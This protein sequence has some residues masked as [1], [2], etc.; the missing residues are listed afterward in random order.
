M[1]PGQQILFFFSALGAF[2]GLIIS[3]YLLI[4][5]KPKAPASYFLGLLLLALTMRITKAVF[6]YFYP[7]LPRIYLQI[8]LSGCFLI[9]PSLFYFTRAALENTVKTPVRWKY[10][11]CAWLV[12]ITIL[13]ILIPYQ[14]HPWDWNHYIVHII[15]AQ[16]VA[17]FVLTGWMLRKRIA[18]L[19][20]KTENLS[21]TEKPILSIF[22]GNAVILI[23]YLIVFFW[24]FSSVYITGAI[25]FS[26]L[27]YLNI[28]LFFSRKRSNTT[29][30]GYAEPE[31]YAKKKIAED[32]ASSLTDKIHKV[33]TEQELYKNPDLKLNDLAK[34][35]NI[36]GHQLSQLL[37]DNLGKSFNVYINEYR[38]ARACELIAS[39]N[40]IKLEEIGYEVGFNAKSTFFTAFKKYRGT[41][42][43]LFREGLSTT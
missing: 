1:N 12:G 38:V 22:F 6:N 39:N 14:S 34:A 35:V 30:L 31:R 27:L 21:P 20:D 42:P 9:G 25:F 5:K 10:I 24:S 23:A 19:F 18:K 40:G 4:F 32:H 13:G 11:Y 17:Y 33:I 2:N 7:D 3:C 37:N 43:S 26:L 8:G 41:T 16:W 29:F 15:Y 36:S 28:P